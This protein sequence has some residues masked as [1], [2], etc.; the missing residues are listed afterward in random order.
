MSKESDLI[1]HW[2]NAFSKENEQLGWFETSPNQTMQLIKECSLNKTSKILNV[3]AGTTTLIESLLDDGYTNIIANDLSPLALQKLKT[4]VYNS[5]QYHLNCIID[6]LTQPKILNTLSNVDLWID[7]AVL[8]FF[9]KEEEQNTYFNL[10]H[11]IVS[12][13]GYVLI[14]VFS[15]D[16]APKCCGLDLQRYNLKM[17]ETKLGSNFKLISSFNYTFIN[18]F[19]GERPYIYTLFQKQ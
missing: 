6:D 8:H 11:Q 18:P 9:L 17:L 12:K 13:N 19:G 16:G 7:R 5:H 3:G 4:R 14:A 15:E 10:I 1:T 2:D